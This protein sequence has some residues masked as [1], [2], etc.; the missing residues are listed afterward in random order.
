L[1][2]FIYKFTRLYLNKKRSLLIIML[3][4]TIPA[5]WLNASLIRPDW[6]MTLFLIITIYNL[7][8][9][10]NKFSLNFWKAV[11]FL[12]LAIATKT[13]AIQFFPL[14]LTYIF[15]QNYFTSSP[16]N[17]KQ[18]LLLLLKTLFL[19]T[20]ALLILKPNI[21]T[22]GIKALNLGMFQVHY[23]YFLIHHGFKDI[24]IR[25]FAGIVSKYY[26]ATSL[27]LLLLVTQTYI[28]FKTLKTKKNY[29]FF[30]ISTS[31]LL[32]FSYLLFFTDKGGQHYYLPI[33]YLTILTLPYLLKNTTSF[34]HNNILVFI[35]VV[36]LFFHIT[37]N[38]YNRILIYNTEKEKNIS[39]FIV[40]TLQ[41]HVN[42]NTSILVICLK[43]V[44]FDFSKLELGHENIF[45]GDAFMSSLTEDLNREKDYVILENIPKVGTF[46]RKLKNKE[47]A[48]IIKNKYMVFAKNQDVYIFKKL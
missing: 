6:L 18:N 17:I 13:Q 38:N 29:L 8:L 12:S 3:S 43:P 33:I 19:M 40:K 25:L 35:I 20:I 30:T 28:F 41:D 7:A 42:K 24:L 14:L 21:F 16:V 39:S 32:N 10:N 5:F 1:I 15:F 46:Q 26:L 11:L 9:D 2:I 23:T 22:I 36:Q 4:I 47:I 34:F 45:L 37:H 27:Y 44:P 31:L 48:D